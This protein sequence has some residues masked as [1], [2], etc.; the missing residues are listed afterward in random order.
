L[1]DA[2][3]EEEWKKK[4]A[5]VDIIENKWLHCFLDPHYLVCKRRLLREFHEM[6]KDLIS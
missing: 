1:F 6:E 3:D 4:K 2:D 5:A